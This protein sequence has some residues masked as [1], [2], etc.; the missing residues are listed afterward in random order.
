MKEQTPGGK[1]ALV[2]GAGRRE[3]IGDAI[4]RE[5]AARGADV[6]F[7]YWTAYDRKM[8]WGA[9]GDD[10]EALLMELRGAGVWAE[11]VELDLSLP[12]SPEKLLDE[13]TEQLGPPSILVN[14]AAYSTRDGFE[15]LDAA[16]FDAHY[17]VN[18]R[19]AALLSVG[20]ARRFDAGSGGRI[21]NLSSGQSL[22]PMPEEL[23]Y[24]S[25]KGAIEAFTRTLA[26]EVG[27]KGITVNAVN[28]GPTD[29]GWMSEE[30][31][32]GLPS[33]FPTGRIGQ[34]EDAARLVAFLAGEDASW[35]TGQV[36]HSEG[37]FIRS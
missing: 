29:T 15:K 10:P 1:V 20:F 36:I 23:A 2:T 31:L 35:I 34:P 16:T 6:F 24:I 8:H 25:T 11:S 26:A 13:A 14:N 30:T 21:V 5:L 3:G 9:D 18:L 32:R 7:T 37:G 33:K 27:H 4:C 12:E 22:G 17:A 19:A 28:P